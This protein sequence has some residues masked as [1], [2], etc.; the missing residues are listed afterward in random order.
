MRYAAKR[1]VTCAMSINNVLPFPAYETVL[2]NLSA[3]TT[4]LFGVK[5]NN[6]S[7]TSVSTCIADS[8][9]ISERRNS[10]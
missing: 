6:V 7:V 5:S 10:H 2:R 4:K 1:E 8:I 3:S 9:V